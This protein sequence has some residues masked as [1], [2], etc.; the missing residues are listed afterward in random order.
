MSTYLDAT[1]QLDRDMRFVATSATGHQMTMD[2]SP[3]GGGHDAGPMPIELVL[4]GLGGCTAMDVLGILRK[5][6]QDVTD[7]RIEVH[8]TRRDEHPKVFTDVT[9]EHIVTG[10]HLSPAA[11]EK[12]VTLSWEKYCSVGAMLEVTA[13]MTHTWRLVEAPLASAA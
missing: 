11:V 2:A 1:V 4:M 9:V 7:Y 3:E 8:G 6:R 10:H 12:A 13:H 5:M